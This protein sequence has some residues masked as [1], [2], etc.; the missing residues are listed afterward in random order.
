[1]KICGNGRIGGGR[2]L[3]LPPDRSRVVKKILWGGL[4]SAVGLFWTQANIKCVCDLF[5]SC[6]LEMVLFALKLS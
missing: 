4:N 5:G 2:G 6:I 1:M 3:I